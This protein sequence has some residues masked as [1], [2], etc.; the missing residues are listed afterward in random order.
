VTRDG[1]EEE[2]ADD[3]AGESVPP[4]H[5]SLADRRPSLAERRGEDF[6][7]YP[8]SEDS[9]LLAGA[10]TEDLVDADPGRVLDVG[11]GSGYV[12]ARLA[13]ATGAW[14]VGSD[15]NPEACRQ[16]R[17]RDLDAVRGDLVTPFRS[18]AFDVVVCNPPYLPAQDGVEWDDWFEVAVTGGETGR[19]VVQRLLADLGR[20]LAPGGA[21]YLLV[22]TATGVDAVVEGALDR[23]FSVVALVDASFPGETLTVLKLVR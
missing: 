2:A 8:A 1:G 16:A 13:E 18:G 17:D 10:V 15:V 12:G 7:V 6:S 11:T 4:S 9:A 20:V 19:E 14:V 21:A 23:G 22:S 3:G 5:P